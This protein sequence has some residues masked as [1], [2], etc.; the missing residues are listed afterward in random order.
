MMGIIVRIAVIMFLVEA[1]T[2]F[3]LLHFDEG[4]SRL[5]SLLDALVLTLI[6]SPI[7][8]LWVIRPYVVARDQ[9]EKFLLKSQIHNHAIVEASQDAIITVDRNGVVTRFNSAAERMFGYE[10]RQALGER[11]D[12]LI[13]PEEYREAHL[14]AFN[15]C[16]ETGV[17]AL[18]GKLTETEAVRADGTRISVE[19]LR[20]LLEGAGDEFCMASI[21]DITER[22]RAERERLQVQKMESL[23][24]LAGG[25]AHD[26]NNMLLPIL[27]LTPMVLRKLSEES[28]ERRKL[29]KVMQAAQ[30]IKDMASRILAF[31]REDEN[32][33]IEVDIFEVVVEAVD[34]LRS[35]LPATVEIQQNMDPNTGKILADAKQIE[36]MLMNFASN[37]ADA[38]GGQPGDFILSLSPEM[39]DDQLA[40]K[41]SN[42]KVGP[43][44]KL[45]VTDTGCGMDAATMSR[46][47]EPLFTTKEKGKGTGL[48][49]SMIFGTVV[50]YGGAISVSSEVGRGTTFIIYLPL[51]ESNVEK[52]AFSGS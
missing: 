7:I 10:S 52:I 22:K 51:M 12:N 11:L 28:S 42:L 29:D 39:V 25:I 48:G 6:S 1:G 9:F 13:I 43:Y 30:R 4:N 3:V 50:K 26:I 18:F 2:M 49:M 37:A 45:T 19:V 35:I 14:K 46:I 32:E 41:V 16:R 34:I 24:S 31:S 5:V 47:Y 21:R 27:N 15:R 20:S 40:A 23:G 38:M 33:P 36:A 44:A 17:A 8:Y